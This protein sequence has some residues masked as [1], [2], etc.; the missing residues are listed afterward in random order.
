MR[1]RSDCHPTKEMVTKLLKISVLAN[2]DNELIT[3]SL[4]VPVAKSLNNMGAK[5]VVNLQS[6]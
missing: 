3:T 6:L 1:L 5:K 2:L 4:K